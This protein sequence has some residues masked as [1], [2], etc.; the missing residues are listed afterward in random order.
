[1]AA[2][3]IKVWQVLHVDRINRKQYSLS[4]EAFAISH[5]ILTH[6]ISP[7]S[8]SA[9]QID[10]AA[11]NAACVSPEDAQQLLQLFLD[12]LHAAR[13][14][15]DSAAAQIKRPYAP[16]PE[17][18]IFAGPEDCSVP[19]SKSIVSD[20]SLYSVDRVGFDALWTFPSL[21]RS[22]AAGTP[23]ISRRRW[24]T[25]SSQ[26]DHWRYRS[27]TNAHALMRRLHSQFDRKSGRERRRRCT[28]GSGLSCGSSNF[29]FK[30]MTSKSLIAR[31]FILGPHEKLPKPTSSKLPMRTSLTPN[32]STNG[33]GPQQIPSS[34]RR[35]DQLSS[36][37]R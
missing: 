28:G 37:S 2:R 14:P 8:Q 6:L 1:M 35:Y 17:G 27:S 18:W 20:Y 22:S 15:R 32:G 4:R 23:G 21:V 29:A 25:K 26:V 24:A 9:S 31:T 10:S 12:R 7:E 19:E 30:A 3:Y 36:L 5:G 13:Y 11:S 34:V 16:L 33:N